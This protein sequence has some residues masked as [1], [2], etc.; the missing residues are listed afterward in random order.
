MDVLRNFTITNIFSISKNKKLK[1]K[2]QINY[3]ID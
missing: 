3:N 2:W 1:K